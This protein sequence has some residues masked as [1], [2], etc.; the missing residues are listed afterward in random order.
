MTK[1]ELIDALE[2]LDCPDDTIIED[3]NCCA[4]TSVFLDEDETSIILSFED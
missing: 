1:R 4:V 2:N 3:E